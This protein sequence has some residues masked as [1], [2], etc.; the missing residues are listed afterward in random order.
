MEKL[1]LSSKLLSREKGLDGELEAFLLNTPTLQA[2]RLSGDNFAPWSEKVFRALALHHSLVELS[3][4]KVLE[5]WALSI[6]DVTPKPFPAL[7]KLSM[8]ATDSSFGHLAPA[9]R[10]VH[11][12]SLSLSG[13]SSKVIQTVSTL[14]ALKKLFIDPGEAG[15][16]FHAEDL[17]AVARNCP[18]LTR[19]ALAMGDYWDAEPFFGEGFSD[20]V[21]DE[22]ARG[23][24]NLEYLIMVVDHEETLTEKTILSLG[25]WCKKL[26]SIATCADVDFWKFV[27]VGEN[28]VFRKLHS[29]RIIHSPSGSV[30]RCVKPG[31]VVERL[32][33]MAPQLRYLIA[34]SYDPGCWSGNS[35]SDE[36]DRLL[37]KEGLPGMGLSC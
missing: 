22:I 28:N 15:F 10:R 18:L 27:N 5:S 7:R 3:V 17:L 16:T 31:G 20:A 19:L 1:C 32:R 34:D 13:P 30:L 37:D 4:P 14:P 29:L 35:V 11:S 33:A 8:Y 26:Y 6:R 21:M 25:K 9:V 12:I 24:P 36:W 23:L 2:V